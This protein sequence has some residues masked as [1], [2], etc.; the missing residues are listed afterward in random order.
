MKRLFCICVLIMGIWQQSAYTRTLVHPEDIAFQKN[1]IPFYTFADFTPQA[2]LRMPYAGYEIENPDPWSDVASTHVPYEIDLVFTKYPKDFDRWRYNYDQLLRD[3]VIALMELDPAFSQK[4]IKWNMYLQTRCQTE[5]EAKTY[6]HG[7]VVK[8]RPKEVRMIDLVKSS[9]D[10]HDIVT[11]VAA[12]KDSTVIRVVERHD[13]QDMLV[14]MDWTGSMYQFGAQLV[15]WHKENLIHNEARIQ[16]LVFFNDGNK[17]KTF[18][19]RIGAT[20]GVYYTYA[21]DLL[22]VIETME[23]V[24]EAGN[25]GDIPENDF[26]ALSK[27]MKMLNGYKDVILIADNASAVRDIALLS[28]IDQ[29]VHII[30]CGMGDDNYINPDYINLAYHTGGSLHTLDQDLMNLSELKPGE[31]KRIGDRD[32]IREN[33]KL[34]QVTRIR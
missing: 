2:V 8:Y 21:D 6:F 10:L 30:L 11:G 3:R 23:R 31:I 34:N 33:G 4:G 12:P 9:E 1:E 18:Q 24:M 5:T 27:S 32:Y 16:H 19:K 22:E 26:E 13:W 17:K 20:G 7:F 15:L 25:G 14:V 29:P 28:E